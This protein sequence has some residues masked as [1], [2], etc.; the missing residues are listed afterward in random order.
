MSQLSRAI[1]ESFN[2]A[3]DFAEEIAETAD[4][5]VENYEEKPMDESLVTE[6]TMWDKVKAH[7][8]NMKNESLTEDVGEYTDRE[9]AAISKALDDFFELAV[10][11]DIPP[12][13]AKKQVL[14]ENMQE[15]LTEAKEKPGYKYNS[16]EG[17]DPEAHMK[18]VCEK[19]RKAAEF[20][21]DE[22]LTEEKLKYE[23]W[24]IQNIAMGASIPSA[25][26][27]EALLEE[28]KNED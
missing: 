5:S 11:Q 18:H 17:Y 7:L 13:I 21:L 6:G 26:L 19:Y 25:K 9:K 16:R 2:I 12:N 14:G 1:Y 20:G 24:R 15:S 8:G 28:F 4:E 10:R 22:P 27:K 3:E 23:D